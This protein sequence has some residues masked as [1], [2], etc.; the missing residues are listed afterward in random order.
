M[1]GYD[2]DGYSLISTNDHK[3]HVAVYTRDNKMLAILLS[4]GVS[5]NIR[6]RRYFKSTP[7]HVAVEANNAKGVELLLKANA[8][9]N[10]VDAQDEP[11][12]CMPNTQGDIKETERII[13]LLIE[14]KA[15]INYGRRPK[16]TAVADA[17]I[18]DDLIAVQILLDRKADPK[19]GLE[20]AYLYNSRQVLDLL[21]KHSKFADTV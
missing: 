3:I 12:L 7:L 20:T 17:S 5:P 18:R 16:N 11:I 13:D 8:D 9:V 14:Y 2:A 10:L 19:N 6:T 15:D 4:Q 1:A 21:Q